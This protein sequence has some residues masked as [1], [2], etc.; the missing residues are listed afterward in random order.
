MWKANASV[1]GG[2]AKAITNA[3]LNATSAYESNVKTEE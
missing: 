3:L 1:P 2:R